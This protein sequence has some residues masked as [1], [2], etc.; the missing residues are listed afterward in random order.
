[1]MVNSYVP[2]MQQYNHYLT[3]IAKSGL[4]LTLFLIGCCLSRKVLLSVGIKPLLHGI[5]LWAI[6]AVA[7]VWA[8]ITFA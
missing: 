2:F 5:V 1:M 3:G 7:A 8:V 4:T 6:I